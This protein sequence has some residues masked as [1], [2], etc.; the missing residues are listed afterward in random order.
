[1]QR[2][3]GLGFH[4]RIEVVLPDGTGSTV[5]L[6]RAHARRLGLNVG[7]TIYLRRLTTS[8]RRW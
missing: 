4:S 5:Q 7:D 6:T 3:V 2:I 1:M 8:A